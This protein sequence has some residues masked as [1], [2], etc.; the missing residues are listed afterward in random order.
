MIETWKLSAAIKDA[1]GAKRFAAAVGRT[2]QT[3]YSWCRDPMDPE[4]DGSP[5]LFDWLEAV[6]DTLAARPEG[7][8][9]L[10]QLRCWTVG[11]IDRAL[12]A[13]QPLPLTRDTL[14]IEA[15]ESVREFG[16]FLRQCCPDGFDRDRLLKEGA[17]AVEAIERLMAAAQEGIR[18]EEAMVALAAR[19]TGRKA[20]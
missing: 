11:T 20:S 6:I 8:P 18:A 7:R 2:L 1:V 13:W 12:G 17:E 4:Q 16:E 9:V 14:A 19:H 15:G 5:N 3:V 10:I